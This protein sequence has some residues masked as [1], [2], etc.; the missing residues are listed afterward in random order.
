MCFEPPEDTMAPILPMV[1]VIRSVVLPKADP[2]PSSMLFWSLTSAL[3]SIL[4]DFS[5][6]TW[7]PSS[8]CC[9]NIDE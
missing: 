2:M 3:M 5:K 4:K 9:M 7:A 8:S 6:F 1:L